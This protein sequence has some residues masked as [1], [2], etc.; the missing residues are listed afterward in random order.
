MGY[1]GNDSTR[2]LPTLQFACC[3]A[4]SCRTPVFP[5]PSQAAWLPLCSDVFPRTPST[6]GVTGAMTRHGRK[7]VSGRTKRSSRFRLVT[8]FSTRTLSRDLPAASAPHRFAPALR[9]R[10][11]ADPCV[12]GI[13]GPTG[14]RSACSPVSSIQPSHAWVGGRDAA[15]GPRGSGFGAR[16]AG[17]CSLQAFA[18]IAG[19]ISATFGS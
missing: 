5:R 8:R 7:E 14:P 3:A 9:R 10:S 11:G 16:Q 19:S 1:L 6:H 13:E 12:E 18:R 2:R 17:G 4:N 15:S